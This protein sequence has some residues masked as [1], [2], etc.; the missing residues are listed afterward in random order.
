M[1]QIIQGKSQN[2]LN[3]KWGSKAQ[4]LSFTPANPSPITLPFIPIHS[5][6]IAPGHPRHTPTSGLLPLLFSLPGIHSL[7]SFRSLFKCHLLIESFYDHSFK[8]WTSHSQPALH[9]SLS[10][11]IFLSSTYHFLICWIFCLFILFIVCLP[12]Q[13]IN[14]SWHE[15]LPILFTQ[16][17]PQ[18]LVQNLEHGGNPTNILN[19]LIK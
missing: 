8:I 12:N 19:W 17:C 13:I 18:S 11:L 14:S 6:H 5:G 15:F 16:L 2:P 9:I 7:T 4:S 10:W 3:G 1:S